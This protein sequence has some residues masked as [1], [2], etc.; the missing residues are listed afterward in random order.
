VSLAGLLLVAACGAPEPPAA[1]GFR[2]GAVPIY[3]NAVYEPG[4]IAG[5]WVQV[6]AF[7]AGEG[8]GCA[9]GRV[10]VSGTAPALT[11]A[12]ELCLDG[13]RLAASGALEPVG[14]GRVR[15]ASAEGV[16]AQDWWLLWVDVDYRTLVV[17]T[18]SGEFG[19]ILDRSGSLPADRMAAA[20]EVLDWNGYDLGRLKGF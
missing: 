16:L 8:A 9:P 17:G 14:P 6:A 18:P 15:P 13:E 7:A 19:F 5:D 12:G 10:T 3:S 4:R 20:R 11:V 2:N 1:V